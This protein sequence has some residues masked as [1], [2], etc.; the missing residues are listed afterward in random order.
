MMILSFLIP[1][2]LA[3]TSPNGGPSPTAAAAAAPP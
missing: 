2:L 1:F 3:M